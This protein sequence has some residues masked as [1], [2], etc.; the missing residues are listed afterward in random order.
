MFGPLAPWHPGEI[1]CL[2]SAQIAVVC[3]H[4]GNLLLVPTMPCSLFVA[5]STVMALFARMRYS[6]RS[7]TM[8]LVWAYTG[9]TGWNCP[10]PSEIREWTSCIKYICWLLSLLQFIAWC[11]TSLL[12]DLG[13]IVV[14]TFFRYL[15]ILADTQQSQL[16]W[17]L[18]ELDQGD[19]SQKCSKLSYCSGWFYRFYSAHT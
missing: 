12:C 10:G 2:Y 5:G 18:L 14:W 15:M 11:V 17:Y 3:A 19:Q 6:L 7:Q 16:S 4:G 8:F 9:R 1:R 13:P